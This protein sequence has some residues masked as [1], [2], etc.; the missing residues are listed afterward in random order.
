MRRRWMV[1]AVVEKIEQEVEGKDGLSLARFAEHDKTPGPQCA[2]VVP[3]LLQGA[4][5]FAASTTHSGERIVVD[6]YSLSA[7]DPEL[8][9]AWGFGAADPVGEIVGV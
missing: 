2:V 6:V 3:Y 5:V 9:E 7:G 1:A 8:L 4:P